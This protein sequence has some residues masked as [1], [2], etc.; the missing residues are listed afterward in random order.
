MPL[1]IDRFEGGFAVCEDGN[2]TI[3][4]PRESLPAAAEE[5]DALVAAEGGSYAVDAAYTQM[6]RKAMQRRLAA[7]LATKED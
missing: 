7:L 3:H 1:I 5:G 6:R 2:E 4:L